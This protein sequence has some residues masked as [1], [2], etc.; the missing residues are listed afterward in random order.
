MPECDVAENSREIVYDQPW[1]HFA[2]PTKN[3]KF[4]SCVRYAPINRNGPSALFNDTD[5]CN[6]DSFNTSSTVPCTEFVYASDEKNIQTEVRINHRCSF[7][8]FEN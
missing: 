3:G 1:L 5:Q 4:D 2:I 7:S 8:I 6:P